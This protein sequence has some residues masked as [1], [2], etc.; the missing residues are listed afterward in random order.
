MKIRFL[1]S[2]L[3]LFSLAYAQ[4]VK[5]IVWADLESKVEFDDPFER[6]TS[7]QLIRLS[8]YAKLQQ[9]EEQVGNNLSKQEQAKKDS[10]Q[11]LLLADDIKIDS[12]LMMRTK[13]TDLRRQ[14]SEGVNAGLH[15]SKIKI[16]GFLLPL[17]LIDEKVTEFLLVPWVGACI[18]TPPPPKNQLIYIK[19][20]E[21]IESVSRFTA[22]YVEGVIT[23]TSKTSTL[24]LVDGSADISSGYSMPD[25][26]VSKY[27]E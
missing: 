26:T 4:D 19:V 25:A 10:L 24:F 17:N 15:G 21:G 3:F 8:R 11:L 13:I 5:E 6:L 16:A 1:V 14:K 20:K 23:C 7:T 22:V 27:K 9:M 12:L 18:H 2:F